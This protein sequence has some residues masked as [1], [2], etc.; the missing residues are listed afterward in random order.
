MTLKKH[1]T[2]TDCKK[3]DV[4]D[5][6]LLTDPKYTKNPYNLISKQLDFK[7]SW[8]KDLNRYLTKEDDK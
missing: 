2:S 6:H 8:I 7:N 3:I 4:K 1:S 5:I